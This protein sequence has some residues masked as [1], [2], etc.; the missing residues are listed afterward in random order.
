MFSLLAGLLWL[1]VP[2]RAATN[3]AGFAVQLV[4]NSRQSTAT[5]SY[6]DLQVKPNQTGTVQM[7]VVNLTQKTVR[8]QLNANTGYTTSNG[9]EAYD[10]ATLGELSTAKY[11]LKTIF[12]VPHKITLAPAASKLITIPYTM[13][14]D[15]FNGILEGAFYFLNL[16]KGPA[17]TTNQK[18]F[19]I[20]NRYALALGVV[21]REHKTPK[22]KPDLA[23]TGMTTGSDQQSKFSPAIGV[24]L[25][26]TQAQL[27]THLKIDGRVYDATGQLQFKT[28][29]KDLGMAPNSN[30]TYLINTKNQRLAAGKYR[31]RVVATAHQQ[32][33]VFTRYFTVTK[34]Q[35]NK[36]NQQVPRDWHWLWWFLIIVVILL[37]ILL[38]WL[39]YRY[40]QR[41]GQ[42]QSK[43]K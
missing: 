20:H 5:S 28:V 30:F 29:R 21:L 35:A 25:A 43:Q 9:V 4:K 1:T 24:K 31:V 17:Q 2:V 19:Q 39:A 15:S 14:A 40:G 3:G 11:Q 10:K 41:K 27:L 8:L 12:K 16:D 37:I 34:S 32:R 36:V 6:F 7:R 26:N 38:I 33:W 42:Q 18:G 23:L 13:P 22:V